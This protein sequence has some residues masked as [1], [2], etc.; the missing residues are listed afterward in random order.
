MNARRAPLLVA[1]AYIRYEAGFRFWLESQNLAKD[2]I[3]NYVTAAGIWFSWCDGKPIDPYNP[4]R[5]DLRAY[6][7]D[8]LR[9]RAPSNVELLKIGLRRFFGYLIEDEKHPGPNPITNLTLR[10][11]ETEPAEP[12]TREELARMLIACQN[13]QERAVYLLLVAGGLRRGEIYGIT[14]DDV[15]LDTNRIKVLGKG[16]Q[17]RESAP[18]QPVVEA[19]WAAMEFSERLCPQ[20]DIE[21][22]WRIVKAIAKRAGIKG[23]IYPHRFRHSFAVLFIENGGTVDQLMHILGH[24]RI[25]MSLYYARAGAKRRA[26]EAQETVDIAGKMLGDLLY[27]K[28][29]TPSLLYSR[30]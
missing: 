3:R 24:K 10:K 12:F 1:P 4:E 6:L 30:S 9:T 16:H 29:R 25:D 15:N 19:V 23:R 28:S 21:V 8:L 5:E 20:A 13:H 18:G 27:F 26:M 11:R 2:T 22:V 7:G 14:R 17:Y